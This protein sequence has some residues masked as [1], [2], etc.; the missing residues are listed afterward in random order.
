MY[1]KDTGECVQVESNK[2][3]TER[4]YPSISGYH[5]YTGVSM[6]QLDAGKTSE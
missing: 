3:I 5:K 1:A 2:N 4:Q 6:V